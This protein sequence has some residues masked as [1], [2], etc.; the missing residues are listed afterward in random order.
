[1]YGHTQVNIEIQD[2]N[3]NPP[4]FESYVVRISVPE[5]VDTGIALYAAHARDRDSGANGVVRYKIVNNGA[6][7]GLFNVDPKLGHLTLTR[8]LD[9][10]TTQRHSLI[11]TAT[12]TGIPPL[13]ANLTVLVEVQ[14]VNDNPPVFERNEYSK[15][16]EESRLV[17]SQILQVTA[18]DLDTG[19]N[20]RLTYRLFPENNTGEVFGIFPNSG[21]LYLK[22]TL[23][24][25]TKDR[26]ELTVSATDNGTPSQSATAK[27][28]IIVSDANDNDPKF[29]KE[30]YEFSIE[31]NLRKGSLV[32]KLSAADED[33][34]INAIIR[35]SL[36]P[37]NISFQINPTSGKSFN[38]YFLTGVSRSKEFKDKFFGV[39]SA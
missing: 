7:G 38:Y 17:N 29:L 21:W 8:H 3:D 35:Y 14:D 26:Y 27:V 6:T 5:N 22:G 12:D 34:G 19:N 25:E 32:G 1:M 13:S 15:S 24:R 39:D 33:I 30:S 16:V 28:L 20:A 2:V 23:D 37:G 11:I 18:L 36:I 31:E 10:E 4:E 9:Y